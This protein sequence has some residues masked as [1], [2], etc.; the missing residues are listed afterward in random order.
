MRTF[1]GLMGMVATLIL[2]GCRGSAPS[3]E[4]ATEERPAAAPKGVADQGASDIAWTVPADRAA[5]VKTGMAESEVRALLGSPPSF[6]EE[7][8]RDGRKLVKWS[9]RRDAAVKG[10]RLFLVVFEHG[11][12]IP[13]MLIPIPEALSEAPVPEPKGTGVTWTLNQA[14]IN[15][16]AVGMTESEVKALIG[17]PS[18]VTTTHNKEGRTVIS[19]GFERAKADQPA[20]PWVYIFFEHGRVVSVR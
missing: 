9:Y 14:Q 15:K 1:A 16:V 11:K 5:Q 2:V 7:T 4:R 3:P 17:N 8:R 18:E 6:S 10:N 12:V 19:W 13:D 20:I